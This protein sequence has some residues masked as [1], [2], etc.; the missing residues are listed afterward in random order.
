MRYTLAGIVGRLA[1]AGLATM[2]LFSIR[3]ADAQGIN[4]PL[5]V[6]SFNK[7]PL[8]D[9]DVD[10]ILA[11][12]SA[13]LNDAGAAR[14]Q[15]Q[16][17]RLSRQGNVAPYDETVLPRSLSL[18]SDFAKFT[19][20]AC[21]KVVER[22]IWCGG[23]VP[24]ALGCAPVPGQGLVVVRRV[25]GLAEN[26]NRDVEPI[27]WLH[28]LGHT[29]GLQHNMQ[30]NLSVMAPGLS[31]TNRSI[32]DNECTVYA[33]AV[34]AAGAAPLAA[35][36]PMPAEA[37]R[38]MAQVTGLK[39]NSLDTSRVPVEDFVK[40]TFL[41]NP[42]LEVLRRYEGDLKKVEGML[43]DPHFSAYRN[44]IIVLLGA[45]GNK[46]TIPLLTKIID[47]NVS[48]ENSEADVA[49][50]LAAPLAM[51]TI[52]NRYGLSEKDIA[53]LRDA[54]QAAFW[55][56]RLTSAK[57]PAA[58]SRGLDDDDVRGLSRDLAIQS[59]RGYAISGS[60]EVRSK[61][62]EKQAG[63]AAAA[64]PEPIRKEQLL[65][66]NEALKLNQISK[67]SGAYSTFSK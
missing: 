16:G 9:A 62:E 47:A 67:D 30:D 29:R 8:T 41:H 43:L 17:V 51:G 55:E 59:T 39:S 6:R 1:V 45:I 15:C 54:S 18:E 22:I 19:A 23:L 42:P 66:I 13:I 52:A 35:A 2:I 32:N 46:E 50:R 34:P 60:P 14:L 3:I 27:T 7:V 57:N 36:T 26:F 5:C 38:Q 64:L 21:V 56:Q 37:T 25:L 24:G 63:T 65:I 28:E 20:D 61:L 44:N 58:G 49:A 4:H 48:P 11:R 10:D 31:P 40:Q 53:I 33:S 12:A